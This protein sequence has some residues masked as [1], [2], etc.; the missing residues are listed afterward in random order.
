MMDYPYTTTFLMPLPG[1]P[2]KKVCDVITGR[3]VQENPNA[4]NIIHAIAGG[5]NIYTNYTGN[6]FYQILLCEKIVRNYIGML[7]LF[8]CF[9]VKSDQICEINGILIG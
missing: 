1:N 8:K 5:V 9:P 6:F 3:L 2:V 4:K 7:F